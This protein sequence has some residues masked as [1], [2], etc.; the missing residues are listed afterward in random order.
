[1]LQTWLGLEGESWDVAENF[2]HCVDVEFENIPEDAG[3]H[4]TCY[5][6][7]TDKKSIAKVERRLARERQEA[8]EDN[9]AIPSTSRATS[10][11]KKL[12]SRSGLP[13]AGSGPIPPAL[14]IICQKKEKFIDRAGKRQRDPL[15]K[16]ETLTAGKH[17]HTHTHTLHESMLTVVSPVCS[18][19]E[20]EQNIKVP[21]LSLPSAYCPPG[22][23]V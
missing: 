4:H 19:D 3:F 1:S 5:R 8:T 15:S 10:P 2:K 18:F 23:A 22:P 9:E 12:R 6:R 21:L 11:T 7:F 17:T 13:I 16:A 20:K 14:C